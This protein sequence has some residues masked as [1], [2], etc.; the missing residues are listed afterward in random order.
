MF[1]A[2]MVGQSL[3]YSAFSEKH[4]TAYHFKAA[5]F[6][7]VDITVISKMFLQIFMSLAKPQIQF[8]PS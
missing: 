3:C 5:P 2:G 6:G 8:L 4:A 1:A 7:N